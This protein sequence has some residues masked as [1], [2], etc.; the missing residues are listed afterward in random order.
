MS[1][2]LFTALREGREADALTLMSRGATIDTVSVGYVNVPYYRVLM[3]KL[4]YIYIPR[5]RE[6]YSVTQCTY[7]SHSRTA[8]EFTGFGHR[9]NRCSTAGRFRI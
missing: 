2:D 1:S 9:T 3:Y 4:T 5:W 6:V 8:G 7:M